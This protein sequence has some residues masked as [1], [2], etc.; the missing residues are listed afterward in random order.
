MTDIVLTALNAGYAHSSFGL[1]CL[2]SNLGELAPRAKILEFDAGL[3]TPEIV[4]AVLSLEPK[5]VGIGVYVWNAAECA[6]LAAELRRLRPELKIVLGGPEVSYETSDRS[7][8]V[9]RSPC[10]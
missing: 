4:E 8:S 2:M 3:R 1:R 6:R 5:I 9:I 10:I 7:V